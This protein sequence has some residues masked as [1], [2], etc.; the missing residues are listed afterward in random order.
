MQQYMHKT[1][2]IWPMLRT[3]TNT[4]NIH[5]THT[6]SLY[7][8]K[9]NITIPITPTQNTDDGRSIKP[10]NGRNHHSNQ[11]SHSYSLTHIIHHT[12]YTAIGNRFKI[13]RITTDI[14]LRN[15]TTKS[16]N[17]PRL[18]AHKST[19]NPA[20]INNNM[21]NEKKEYSLNNH[22]RNDTTNN[23]KENNNKE[24]Q[25]KKKIRSKRKK[26]TES[27]KIDRMKMFIFTYK[28]Q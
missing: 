8:H 13:I 21:E 19:M 27:V 16:S 10:E 17:H 25:P 26:P 3:V 14:K 28:L 7:T 18:F 23:D 22:N 9:K 6:H 24:N 11:L 5:H 1:C 15:T 20:P 2:P 12:V 4:L